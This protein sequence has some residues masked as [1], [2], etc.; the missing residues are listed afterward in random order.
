MFGTIALFIGQLFATKWYP[1]TSNFGFLVYLATV[2]VLMRAIDNDVVS[3]TDFTDFLREVA[4]QGNK[5]SVQNDLAIIDAMPPDAYTEG[6]T[7]KTNST[8]PHHLA[9]SYGQVESSS[10]MA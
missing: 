2:L 10:E 4:K 7:T 8:T 5:I 9:S 6:R 1:F 3:T